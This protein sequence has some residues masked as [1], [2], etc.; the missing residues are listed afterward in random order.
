M[1]YLVK[2][3]VGTQVL[4]N[5]TREDDGLAVDLSGATVRMYLRAK[6]STSILKTITSVSNAEDL[7]QGRAIFAFANGDL[8]LS[9]GKYEG[10][11]EAEFDSGNVETVFEIIDFYLRSDFT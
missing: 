7:A 9:E 5:L 10:E 4:A 11:I 8:D 2:D 1:F 6:G 3:D